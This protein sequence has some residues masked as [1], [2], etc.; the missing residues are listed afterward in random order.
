MDNFDL[1]EFLLE[2]NPTR[3]Y[4]KHGGFKE[5]WHNNCSVYFQREGT[6]NRFEL[7]E[8]ERIAKY[9]LAERDSSYLLQYDHRG[10][11]SRHI[12]REIPDLLP[13]NSLMIFNDTKVVPA[14]LHFVRDTGARIEIFCLE[15]VN[16]AEYNLSF[17][18]T[19]VCEWKCVIGNARKW[20]K[21]VLSLFVP[22]NAPSEAS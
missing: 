18:A 19:A 6:Y 20:K 9:P 8:D 4:Y 1:Y 17:A 12:F 10:A 5:C 3:V 2:S 11:I 15:P 21:D 13:D 7:D 16:P 14:R 22:D